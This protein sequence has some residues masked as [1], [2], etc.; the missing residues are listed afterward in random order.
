M[1][2]NMNIACGLFGNNQAIK[3]L[4]ISTRGRQGDRGG[5]ALHESTHPPFYLGALNVPK[6]P[7]G[8]TTQAARA[9]NASDH[10]FCVSPVQC[11]I[12]QGAGL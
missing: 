10:N 11:D 2:I 12:R 3:H 9:P 1:D 8:S 7:S 4:T 5:H 6:N